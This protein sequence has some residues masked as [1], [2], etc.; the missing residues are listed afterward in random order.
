VTKQ[1]HFR[2]VETMIAVEQ[3]YKIRSP[4]SDPVELMVV[5]AFSESE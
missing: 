1:T 5:H 3:M 2:V 4:I